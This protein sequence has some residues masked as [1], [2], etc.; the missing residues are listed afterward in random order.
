MQVGRL[1]TPPATTHRR[2]SEQDTFARA[3]TWS[4]LIQLTD[5]M[6]R[7]VNIVDQPVQPLVQA[8][9]DRVSC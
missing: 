5:D 8:R 9:D 6:S 2:S 3:R 4:I 1:S 7:G